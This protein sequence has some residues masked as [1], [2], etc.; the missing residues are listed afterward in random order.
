[1]KMKMNPSLLITLLLVASC[2]TLHNSGNGDSDPE[3]NKPVPEEGTGE[4]NGY[5]L[6]WQDLFNEDA[7]DESIWN[8]E[9]NGNG[10]GNAELQYYR[11]ENVSVGEDS[12][13]GRN[14]LIITAKK[15]SFGG[16]SFT[17]GRVNTRGNKAFTYGKVEACIKL[18]ST[19][20][21][22]WPAFW[23]MGDNYDELGWPRCGEIDILEMGNSQ[24]IKN[25]T[26]DRFF[27]G[28]CHWG[29]YKEVSPNNWAY[30]N[31]AKSSVWDYSLQDGQFHL[32]TLI[33]DENNLKMYVDMDK[34]PS[35]S[36]YF[37]M[38]ITSKDDDW[39]VGHYFHHDFFILFNMAVG[40]HFTGILNPD[41]ITALPEG[42][43]EMYVDYVKVYQKR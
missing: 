32:F 7:L 4:S 16:K 33:W 13:S 18:P 26:Q 19:S 42:Q 20:D 37:E 12:E 6:V 36:P 11:R 30:P 10:G 35:K 2:E 34:Y 29:Y 9:V 3:D 27:N 17:S 14:C 8:I 24:G 39:G 41:A 21:G 23:M 5:S 40:G 31:Y 43:A 22:L 1:M 15:E 38:G 25:S 28:A